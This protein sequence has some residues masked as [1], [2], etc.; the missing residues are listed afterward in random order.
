MREGV[1]FNFK[2]V[3]FEVFRVPENIQVKIFHKQHLET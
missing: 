1:K 3:K 2:Y